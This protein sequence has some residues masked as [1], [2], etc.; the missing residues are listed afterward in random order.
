LTHFLQDFKPNDESFGAIT[1]Q[2]RVRIYFLGLGFGF[3]WVRFTKWARVFSWIPVWFASLIITETNLHLNIF[4]IRIL[5]L[6]L[7]SYILCT[8]FWC[9]WTYSQVLNFLPQISH[10]KFFS[11]TCTVIRCRLKLVAVLKAFSQSWHW[12]FL[13]SEC[14]ARCCFNLVLVLNSA[15]QILHSQVL[16]SEW[17]NRMCFSKFELDFNTFL[18]DKHWKST[19]RIFSLKSWSAFNA[20]WLVDGRL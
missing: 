10:W 1:K 5:E 4:A 6:N 7:Q 14:F 17:T 20:C 16:E 2:H 19:E 15:W 8:C 12:N 18:Q 13:T 3:V 9:F 11:S